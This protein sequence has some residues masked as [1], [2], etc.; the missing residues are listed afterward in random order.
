M[1][2]HCSPE[3]AEGGPVALVEEGDLI[4]IDIPARRLNIV[5]I[6]GEKKTPEEIDQILSERRK[7]WKPR[8]ARYQRG[9]LRLLSEHAVSPMKGAWLS[10]DD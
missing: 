2:G 10:Y 8:K 6:H 5:G 4:E 7:N 3:A 9:V 1:I